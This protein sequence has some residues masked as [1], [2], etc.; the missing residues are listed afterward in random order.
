MSVMDLARL[1]NSLV[2][3]S[4]RK[5]R[6]GRALLLESL[7]TLR[8]AGM[9]GRHVGVDA[10]LTGALNLYKSAGFQIYKRSDVYRKRF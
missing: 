3:S 8:D 2:S 5:H 6:V 4:W 10:E 1:V 7:N 9:T